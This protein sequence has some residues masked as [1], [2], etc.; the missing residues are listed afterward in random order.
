M[1]AH[2]D[3][4]KLGEDLA[5]KFLEAEGFKIFDRNYNYEKAEIDIVAFWEE[6]AELHFV[7]VKTRS[8]TEFIKPE[9]ALTERQQENI[10]KV[11]KFYLR[12]RQLVTVPVV[13]DVIAIGMDDPANPE[14]THLE[15]VFRPR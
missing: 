10:Y 8:N 6:P 12:E 2:N 11:A 13:F 1:A 4:G 3:L 15:D 9:E 14:I 5:V 7:E